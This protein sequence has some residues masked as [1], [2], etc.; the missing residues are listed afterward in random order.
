M[1]SNGVRCSNKEFFD[2]TSLLTS[3]VKNF[4]LPMLLMNFFK[5][6]P[7]DEQ[8]LFLVKMKIDVVSHV[9]VFIDCLKYFDKI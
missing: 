8:S 7:A 6:S 4:N 3:P 5:L 2:V 1:R 9:M